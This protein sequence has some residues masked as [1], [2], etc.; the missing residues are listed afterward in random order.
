MSQP[1]PPRKEPKSTEP[2]WI[3]GINPVREALRGETAVLDK[4]LLGRNSDDDRVLD[5][6]RQARERRIP[7]EQ[8][9]R[10]MLT[11]LVG[12][13]HHQ[14]VALRCRSFPY[15]DAETLLSEGGAGLSPLLL[16]DS[17][18]DPQNLGA[19]L[20]SG[21]Y[22]G[23]GGVI[24]PRDRAAAV[25]DA[26]IKVSA[27]AA[28]LIPVAQVTNLVRTLERLKDVGLW[29]VGLDLQSNQSLYDAD[30]TMPLGLVVGN[31]HKGLRP[32]VREHCDL[33]LHI[34]AHGPLQSLNA[35][36]ATAIAL[37]EIQRQRAKH[38]T[39]DKDVSI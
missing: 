38:A 8:L 23:A 22:L 11:E 10:E 35:A 28:S 12:H 36:T 18:Q 2:L 30:L 31:E 16:L 39:T 25:T 24:L 6:E 14:G 34:P 37:A 29:V 17:I 33:L 32:L 5:L 3:C 27:G 4:L 15:A 7:V 1:K 26:V 21:C 19:I 20:R 9:N 13:G